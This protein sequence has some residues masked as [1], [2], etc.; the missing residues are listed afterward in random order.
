M[1]IYYA[2]NISMKGWNTGQSSFALV[3]YL[4]VQ[5]HIDI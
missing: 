1:I 2:E 5:V 3:S 4:L